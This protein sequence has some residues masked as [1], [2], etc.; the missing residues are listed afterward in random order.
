MTDVGLH[1]GRFE[2]LLFL[3]IVSISGSKIILFVLLSS[4]VKGIFVN[5]SWEVLFGL[6]ASRAQLDIDERINHKYC[7][8]QYII[9]NQPKHVPLS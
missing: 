6:G 3:D 5:V 9:D 4:I 2:P 1:L 7:I 8:L